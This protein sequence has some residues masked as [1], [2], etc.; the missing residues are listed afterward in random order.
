M[1]V[2]SPGP[3]NRGALVPWA[4]ARSR[5]ERRAAWPRADVL[6]EELG[7]DGAFYRTR[8]TEDALYVFPGP[9]GVLTREECADIVDG[10]DTPSAWFKIGDPRFLR[11]A[12]GLVLLT[13]TSL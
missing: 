6:G 10:N 2:G 13:Y 1:S 5:T 12:D 7:G 9:T 8:A 11:L 4:H 3:T